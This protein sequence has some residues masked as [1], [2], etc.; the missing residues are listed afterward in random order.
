[1]INIQFIGIIDKLFLRSTMLIR[2]ERGTNVYMVAKFGFSAVFNSW[3]QLAAMIGAALTTIS[4]LLLWINGNR[5]TRYLIDR[6]KS[7]SKK[8]KAV[9]KAAEVIR[10]ELLATQ[11]NQDIADQKRRLAEM[12]ADSLRKEMDK[13]R[14]RYANAEGALKDRIS[15]LKDMNIT[16]TGTTSGTTTQNLPPVQQT[17]FL[18]GQQTKMLKKLL[19]SGPKGELDI[20]SVLEDPG[21]HETATEFKE[22]FD[23]QGWSTSEIVQSAFKHPPEGFVLVIHSKQT[24]PSYAKF[25]QRTLTTI[26]LSVSAQVNTKYPEWSISLIVGQVDQG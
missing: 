7:A 25:L 10:K 26:G 19:S 12:D 18:D 14:S 8:I 2:R 4:L 24:A 3:M 21:S 9:E 1:M 20:I 6:E 15:E 16:Q 22:L 17:G 13:I 23:G 5:M 11:Q